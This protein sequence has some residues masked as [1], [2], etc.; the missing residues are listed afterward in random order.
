MKKVYINLVLL[1]SIALC[2]NIVT[3]QKTPVQLDIELHE[4]LNRLYIRP[5]TYNII[6]DLILNGA[7]AN[8]KNRFGNN[9]LVIATYA[10]NIDMVNFLISHG[11][12]VNSKDS[13]GNP[14]LIIATKKRNIDIVESLI[15]S[16]ANIDAKGR[17]G[18]NAL[19]IAE[20]TGSRDIKRLLEEHTT[21]KN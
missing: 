2:N 10:G 4:I 9:A 14:V 3:M 18:A 7:N 16:G 20:M 11:A 1:S 19:Q 6:K 21:E 8:T 12:D 13:N 5:A 17:Y 15:N